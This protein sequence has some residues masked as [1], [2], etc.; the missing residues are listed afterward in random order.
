MVHALETI[1]RLLKPDGLLIDIHP[2]SEPAS[3]EVRSGPY[4]TLAGWVQEPDDYA[5]YDLADA[6]LARVVAGGLFRV[7]RQGVFEFVWHADTLD[8]LRAFMAEDWKEATIDDI[9]A[10]RIEE[11]MS[12]PERD[13]EI[14]V[15]ESIRIARLKPLDE[16]IGHG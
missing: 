10:G 14:V 4:T 15:R 3:I 5:E 8:D 6:A 12:T 13:K 1:H 16:E 2:T 11:R 7:E 9:T